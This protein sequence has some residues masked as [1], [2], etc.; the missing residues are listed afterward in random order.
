MNELNPLEQAVYDLIPRGFENKRVF[1]ELNAHL[2]RRSFDHIISALRKKGK[3][4]GAVRG[5]H[6]GYFVAT[7]EEERGIALQQ[8]EA[9]LKTEM[10]IVAAMKVSELETVESI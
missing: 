9:Q 6:G 5:K 1:K 7:N 10:R 8:L 2:E 4:I 3:V